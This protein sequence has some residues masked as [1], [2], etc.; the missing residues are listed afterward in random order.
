MWPPLSTML[1]YPEPGGCNIMGARPGCICPL[2]GAV[3][4]FPERESGT[5]VECYL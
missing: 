3:S 1:L 2:G 4:S 5:G